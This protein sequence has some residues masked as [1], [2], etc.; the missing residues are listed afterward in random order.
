VCSSRFCVLDLVRCWQP[1]ERHLHQGEQS[2]R[3][4]H[5]SSVPRFQTYPAF[6]CG[7]L[8]LQQA[9]V[10]T[11]SL[12]QGVPLSSPFHTGCALY[13]QALEPL[14][15]VCAVCR[16]MCALC[17]LC[18]VWVMCVPCG[19]VCYLDQVNK[20]YGMCSYIASL[21]CDVLCAMCVFQDPAPLCLCLYVFHS[22]LHASISLH[23]IFFCATNQ[24]IYIP[25][26]VYCLLTVSSILQDYTNFRYFPKD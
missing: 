7:V 13:C 1:V 12:V 22:L 4:L 5:V 11:P 14:C 3:R 16:A 21:C 23:Y 18:A 25:Y 19:A 8:T 17:V 2:C 9:Q 6:S 26:C 20:C 10:H 24:A 15:A